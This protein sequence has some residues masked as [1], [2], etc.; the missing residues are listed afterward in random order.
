MNAIAKRSCATP[1]IA[2]ATPSA[3]HS[4]ECE[5]TIATWMMP[6]PNKEDASKARNG[7]LNAAPEP[8]DDPWRGYKLGSYRVYQTLIDRLHEAIR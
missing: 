5:G 4:P 8:A 1:T 6:A 3:N 2:N 7:Q